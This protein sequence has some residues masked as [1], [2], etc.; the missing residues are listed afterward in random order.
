MIQAVLNLIS[1]KEDRHQQPA[2]QDHTSQA[3]VARRLSLEV[4]FWGLWDRQASAS[5]PPLALWV[6]SRERFEHKEP[7][8]GNVQQQPNLNH[9]RLELSNLPLQTLSCP[10]SEGAKLVSNF[11]LKVVEINTLQQYSSLL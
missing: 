10:L 4:A 1:S 8:P 11:F 3:P 9:D 7:Q 5:P 2:R 6:G